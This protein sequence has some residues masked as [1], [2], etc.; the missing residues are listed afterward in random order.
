MAHPLRFHIAPLDPAAECIPLPAEEAHHALRVARLQA[1]AE[2]ALFDG[3]GTEMYGRLAPTGRRNAEVRVERVVR[4]DRPRTTITL[5]VG[6]LHRDRPREEVVRRATELGLARVCFWNA[7]HSQH[8]AAPDTRLLKAA[9]AACKQCGR[10][11]LPDIG[12]RDSLDALLA[13]H[14]GPCIY[15]APDARPEPARI[16]PASSLLLAVGPEG[17]FSPRERALL[18]STG[19]TPLSLGAHV[20][21]SETAAA[22]LAALAVHALGGLGPGITTQDGGAS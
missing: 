18:Q 17:D 11:F 8:P 22:L 19:A 7:D 2:V 21:R 13:E 1:G 15:G 16:A 9:I 3:A 6:G 4:L 20:Y 5:A 12:F 10:G 14:A